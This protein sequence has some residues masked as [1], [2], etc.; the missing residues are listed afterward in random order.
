MT[1]GRESGFQSTS[2][3][4]SLTSH[5]ESPINTLSGST[6]EALGGVPIFCNSDSLASL[7]SGP[8]TLIPAPVLRRHS[9]SRLTKR[10]SLSWHL[11]RQTPNLPDTSQFI[12]VQWFLKPLFFEVPQRETIPVFVGRDWLYRDTSDHLNSELPTNRGVIISGAPGTGKTSIILTLVQSSCFGSGTEGGSNGNIGRLANQVVAFHFCQIDNSVSCL[13][14]EWVHSLAAQLAQAPVLS[15]YHQLLSTDH[16]L[17]TILSLPRCTAD[18]HTALVQGVLK[19]LALLRQAGKIS[20]ET[21]V[22]LIDALCDSQ[23]H[24]PDLGDTLISFLA[25]HLPSFPAWLKIVATVRSCMREEVKAL[26]FHTIRLQ[27]TIIFL[28]SH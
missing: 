22:I 13:V 15:A 20:G 8:L 28:L 2:S 5:Y 21:C 18:P 23:F 26:P 11:G 1:G 9:F 16:S 24:R 3:L 4:T 17:R 10:S 25:R 14:G 12:P 27:V 7:T 19:P 6:L